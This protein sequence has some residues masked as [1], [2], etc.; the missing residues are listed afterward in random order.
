MFLRIGIMVRT[1]SRA[2]MGQPVQAAQ[3][4]RGR[5]RGRPRRVAE[6]VTNV[7]SPCQEQVADSQT[8]ATESYDSD[9]QDYVPTD[10]HIS[11]ACDEDKYDNVMRGLRHVTRVVETL[12]NVV[13][14]RER[15]DPLPHTV[16]PMV[17]G[18]IPI[19]RF[20]RYAPPIFTGTDPS[21]DPQQFLDEIWR[22]C[23]A[24]GCTDHRSVILASFRLQ[25]NVALSWYD[26]KKKERPAG[27]APWSWEEFSTMFL[28][29]FMPESTMEARAV[30]FELLKQGQ[31]T[32][33]EYDIRFTELSK[34][35]SH[36]I[37]NERKKIKR[38]IRGLNNDLF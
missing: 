9:S 23:E 4:V 20:Q 1:R 11:S 7:E 5:G 29:R 12:A 27:A 22:R 18:D 10:E 31:M 25:G 26:S 24:I 19:G 35:G 17:G 2:T 33:T 16:A 34:Y 13:A 32:V 30:E 6:P 38:F 21:E 8:P 14:D 15:R 3:S 36:M 37:P 28:E